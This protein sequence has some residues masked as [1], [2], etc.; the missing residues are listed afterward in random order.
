MTAIRQARPIK[1][2]EVYDC[3]QK[4]DYKQITL[5]EYCD[6]FYDWIVDSHDKTISGLDKFKHK[7]FTLGTSQAFD[8]FVLR[9]ATKQVVNF[10]GD[11]QYHACISKH[12]NYKV[13][14]STVEL[15][16]GQA[17]ILSFPFSDTGCEHV[18][19]KKILETCNQLNIPVCLD[20]AYWGIAKDLTL[21]LNDW[22][23]VQEV[24]CSLSKPF[25]ALETHRVGIRFSRHYTDDGV[26]MMNEVGMANNYSM[27]L[28]YWFMQK[29]N[30]S[31]I[32]KKY[33]DLYYQTCNNLN[34]KSTD[35]VIFGIGDQ[36][37]SKFNRGIKNNNR[38]CISEYLTKGTL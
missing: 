37:Y 32:W 1:D 16:K 28:G 30:N 34:L 35:T 29:F 17:L 36:T 15:E 3:Y 20:I 18:D 7:H 26:C 24:A 33:I 19:F 6:A 2:Q 21:Q 4:F 25:H 12:I 9:H 22:H 31:Y 23:C 14:E 8:S 13:I 38:V 5:N 11:F 27:S 10:I